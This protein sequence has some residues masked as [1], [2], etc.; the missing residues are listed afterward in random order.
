M[1]IYELRT[2]TLRVGNL[3]P[4]IKIYREH[5]WPAF[6]AGGY[7]KKLIG[8]F[9][10]DIGELNQIVHLWKFDDDGDRRDHWRRFLKDDGLQ[11]FIGKIAPEIVSQKN[12]LLLA[13]PWGPHP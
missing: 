13:A 10:S 5:G 8:Y 9:T 7:D 6:Q 11:V 12:Q 1:A 2:Y 3:G 4:V